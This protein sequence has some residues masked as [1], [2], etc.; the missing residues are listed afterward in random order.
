[1]A[2]FWGY[3]SITDVAL[4]DL[5]G[6]GDDPSGSPSFKNA[7]VAEAAKPV[8]AGNQTVSGDWEFTGGVTLPSGKY[9]SSA[10]IN[11]GTDAAKVV[12]AD[13]LAGANI[14]TRTISVRIVDIAAGVTTGDGK[15][16][17]VVPAE[18]AGM[19][20]ITVG[21]HNYTT[22]SSGN[23]TVMIHNLTDAANMLTVG[24]SINATDLDSK[25]ATTQAEIDTAHDD[26]A[27]GDVLRFD[28]DTAGTGTC[29]LELRMGFRLPQDKL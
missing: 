5:L 23:P 24:V 28:V 25:D 22:S 14:G 8:L 2:E 21:L 27:E 29:G 10:E 13:S 26:V 7:T 12:T 19:N 1:M 3:T 18:Y 9:A 20:L 6:V 17:W 16:Y 4:T 15:E 11:T